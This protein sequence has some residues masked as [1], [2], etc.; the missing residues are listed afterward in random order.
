MSE[1]DEDRRVIAFR[2]AQEALHNIRKHSR[3]TSVEVRLEPR[4]RGF[5]L[6]IADDGVGFDPIEVEAG[7]RGHLGLPA[8]RERAELAGGRL[9]VTSRPGSGTTIQLWLPS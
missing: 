5:V 9:E 8:M 3:A 1:P 6:I 4:E 2:V 7:E